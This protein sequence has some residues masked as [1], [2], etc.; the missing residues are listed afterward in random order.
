[1]R[2]FE[3]IFVPAEARGRR[4]GA[5][6]ARGAARRRA[7]ADRRVVPAR[8]RARRGR[9]DGRGACTRPLRRGRAGRA[10]SRGRESRSSRSCARCAQQVG[11]ERGRVRPPRR[12]EPGHPRHGGDAG[13]A[14]CAAADRRRARRRAAAC[15]RLAE[16][17]RDTVMAARTLLQQ[18][19]PTT[20]GVKAAG[21][22]VGVVEARRRLAARRSSCRRS[23]A[24]RPGRS[25]RS[26]ATGSRC[27]GCSPRSSTCASRPCRGTRIRTPVAELA[28][29]L[30]GAAGAAA[31]IAG[32]RRA[33]RAD[34]G[35]RG[36][37]G[38]G[39]RLVDDAAQAQPDAAVLAR[40]LRAPCARERRRAPRVAPCRST[41]ARRA[42]GTPSGTALSTALAL[43]RRRGGGAFAARSTALRGR[44]R[45][46]A[47][48]HRR[49]DA[50]RGAPLGTRGRRRRTT[51][52]ARR[53]R[54]STAHSRSTGA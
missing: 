17:H 47:R 28:G 45:A 49:R 43:D 42:P 6:L 25:R 4:L 52:S 40:R 11:D 23:S 3:A 46:H 44:R 48:E 53:L 27:C 33:A 12:D 34:R 31:K 36:G 24:A 14:A 2:P 32:R 20:F 8:T 10:G 19:V 22:L 16:A 54:S 26:G 37:R 39:R 41:S 13:R 5:R 35:R 21:W 15:A 1:M 18:A 50:L 29:A 7:R 38:G 51:I 9:G 30:A